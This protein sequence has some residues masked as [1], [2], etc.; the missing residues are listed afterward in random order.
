MRGG[1]SQE[2]STVV[3]ILAGG[4]ILV[5][6]TGWSLLWEMV[7]KK[8]VS[9]LHFVIAYILIPDMKGTLKGLTWKVVWVITE[10]FLPKGMYI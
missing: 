2:F 3:C 5:I 6:W 1:C 8:K 9:V 10:I 4:K 7:A